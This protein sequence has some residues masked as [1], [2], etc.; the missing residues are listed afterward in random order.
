MNPEALSWL[1]T[2]RS[3][4]ALIAPAPDNQQLDAIL[5]TATT[6]PDHG[7]LRPYRFVVVDQSAQSRFGDALV[8]AATA[9]TDGLSEEAAAGLRRKAA[10]AP[11]QVLVIFSPATDTK[12]PAWEQRVAA[13]CTGYAML[14]AAAAQGLGAAWRSASVMHGPGL[15]EFL[16]RTPGEEFLGWINLG[17]IREAPAGERPNADVPPRISRVGA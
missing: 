6:V 15:D 8:A 7:R 16:E 2:R 11:M 14:L 1:L 10:A 13:S 4:G 17:Q 5:Q 12:I 3:I 9:A